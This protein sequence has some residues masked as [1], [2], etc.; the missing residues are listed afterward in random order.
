LVNAKAN[1]TLTI[2]PFFMK[3]K[4]SCI[5]LCFVGMHLLASSNVCTKTCKQK[6]TGKKEITRSEPAAQANIVNEEEALSQWTL[7]PFHTVLLNL[8]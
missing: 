3:L 8:Y 7:S 1:K 2:K 5:V 6:A 4:I